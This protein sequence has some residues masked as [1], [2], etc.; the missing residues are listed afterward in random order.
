[1]E[2]GKTILQVKNLKK[3]F[4]IQR[5]LF[6]RTVGHVKAVDDIS[7]ELR[8]GETLG[9]VGESGCG[10]TTLGRCVPRLIEPTDGEILFFDE[11]EDAPLS[12][13]R[14]D[15]DKIARLRRKTQMIFQDPMASLNP[16]MTVFE[17]VSEPLNYNAKLPKQTKRDMAAELLE[18]TGIRADYMD[19]YPHQFSGGQRQR[20]GIARAL[21]LN[22]DVLICDEAISALDVSVQAQII[23]MFQRLQRELSLS[24]LFI[25]HD[26]SVV[27][28]MSH[29]VMVLYL[30]KIAE[31]AETDTLFK[32]PRH[33]YTESLLYSIPSIDPTLRRKKRRMLTGDVPN[34][35]DPPSGCYFHTRCPYVQDVCRTTAPPLRE[36]TPGH[37]SACHFADT[38]ELKGY[39][40]IVTSRREGPSHER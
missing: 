2:N 37:A 38:L 29:R 39:E 36:V 32:R 15:R 22:P 21:I 23:K 16:R 40:E 9:I 26:L 27:E 5:G 3:H 6:R 34:P 4:P 11:A 24:Y 31:T 19:R 8:K 25:A 33:P 20:I 7:F 12:V 18:R 30:G 17:I 14:G 10:K 13:K 35:A 28:H 1:M